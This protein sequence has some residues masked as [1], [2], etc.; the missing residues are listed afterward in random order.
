MSPTPPYGGVAPLLENMSDTPRIDVVNFVSGINPKSVAALM[1]VTG[2]ARNSG[3]S[4]IILN[5]SSAGGD[6]VPIFG[7]Y[8]HLRSLGIP[9]VSHNIG[10][11]ESA[12]VLLYLAADTRLA[13]PHSRFMLHNFHW[14]FSHG[15]IMHTDVREKGASLDFDAQRYGHIFNE[16]TQG[17]QSPIDIFKALNGDALFI[18]TTAAISAGICSAVAEPT[19][20]AGACF[21][22]I[23]ASCVS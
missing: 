21:W 17:A 2:R 3:S 1:E 10:N 23:D 13:A 12:A 14:S 22:W 9:L 19:V 16:R 11:I 8:Y 15:P 4:R 5:L 6:L 7:V 18:S 20:P